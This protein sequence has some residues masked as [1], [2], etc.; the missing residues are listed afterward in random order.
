M[1]IK[2][3][4]KTGYSWKEIQAEICRKSK[5]ARTEVSRT[6][7]SRKDSS[8]SQLESNDES[9]SYHWLPVSKGNQPMYWV[10]TASRQKHDRQF[11]SRFGPGF[12]QSSTQSSPGFGCQFD[13]FRGSPGSFSQAFLVLVVVMLVYSQ[14]STEGSE[15]RSA[16][17]VA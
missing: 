9:Q 4:N 3:G 10:A 5:G 14:G 7:S 16:H 2:E 1:D 6:S 13:S 11:T 17:L 8:K 12:N 15:W